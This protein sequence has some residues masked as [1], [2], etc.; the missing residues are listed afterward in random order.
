MAFTHNGLALCKPYMNLNMQKKQNFAKMQEGA[1]KDVEWCFGVLQA[2]FGIIQNLFKLWKIYKIYKIMTTCV[3]F[4][5]VI[6][7]DEK[8]WNFES[9]FHQVDIGQLQFNFTFYTYMEGTSELENSQTHLNMILDLV[10]HLWA[11]KGLH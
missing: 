11:M 4:H 8:D 3:N 5:N 1:R 6:I 2:R 7:E 10:K 9:L